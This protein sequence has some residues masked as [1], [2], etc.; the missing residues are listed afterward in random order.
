MSIEDVNDNTPEFI[1]APYQFNLD[2]LTP[3]GLTVFRGIYALDRDK[4]NTANSEISFEITGGNSNRKFS[5]EGSGGGRAVL[6][7]RKKLDFDNGDRHFNLTIRAQVSCF[8]DAFYRK[9]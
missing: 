4:P 3:P 8:C 9:M 1:N 5:I 2:E 7:L 6:V